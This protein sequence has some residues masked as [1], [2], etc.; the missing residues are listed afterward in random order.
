MRALFAMG[1]FMS[2]VY[3]LAI[4]SINTFTSFSVIASDFGTMGGGDSFSNYAFVVLFFNKV[5]L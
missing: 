2:R 1:Y 3:V 5:C 4:F